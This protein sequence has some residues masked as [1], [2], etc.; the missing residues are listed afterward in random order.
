L[1]SRT[2]RALLLVVAVIMALVCAAPASAASLL[3]TRVTASKAKKRTCQARVASGSTVVKRNVTA[4]ATG[5]LRARTVGSGSGDWDLAVF[6]RRDGRLVAASAYRGPNELA[7]GIAVDREPLT[8]QACRRSGK[9]KSVRLSVD[10]IPVPAGSGDPIRLVRIQTP[11]DAS[12]RVLDSLGLDL[13]EHAREG[14]RE[15]L[16][17]S[18]ADAQK[19]RKA[20]LIFTVQVPDVAAA[21]RRAF[22]QSRSSNA[23]AGDVPSGRTEYRRLADYSADMKRLAEENPDLVKPITLPY[24]TLEGRPVEGIEITQDVKKRD[25]KPVFLQMGVHHAREWPSGEHAMEWAFEMVNGLR[26]G[27]ERVTDLL[28]RSRVIVV[29]IVNPDG[30]NLTREAGF[31]IPVGPVGLLLE[32]LGAVEEFAYKRRNCR[33]QDGAFPAAGE[34]G[35]WANRFL[36]VDPNR[37][38]GG[39][40][41]GPGASTSA[42]DDTYRGAG[43]FSE[44]ET[45]NIKALV[46]RRQV[47][48]L[49][50]NHTYSDLV[51]RPPGIKSEGDP[52]DEPVYKELGDAMAA[53]N[54][55]TSEKSWELYDTTGTTEDWSYYATGGLGFTFEIG[56]AADGPT[57]FE[58]LAGVG[59]HPPYPIGVILEYN[60]KQ[61]GGGGN[62]EAYFKALESTANTERHSVIKGEAPAGATLRL[63]KEFA[64]Y[65]SPVIQADGSITAPQSFPDVLDTTMAVDSSGKFEWHVNPSTRPFAKKSRT[66]GIP[67]DTPAVS[68][69]IAQAT[70][71]PP[72]A[73]FPIDVKADGPKGAIGAWMDGA[74]GDDWDMYLYEGS[75]TDPTKEVASSAGSS[76]DERL[77]YLSPAPG[78]YTLE[79]RYFTA[80]SGWTGGIDL[81]GEKDAVTIPAQEETWT[82]TCEQDGAVKATYQVSVERGQQVDIS[83]ACKGGGQVGAT[84]GSPGAGGEAGGGEGAGG[85]ST[86]GGSGGSGGSSTDTTA[87]A[88]RLGAAAAQ[89]ALRQHGIVA[90]VT[91]NE[92]ATAVA[93]GTIRIAGMKKALPLSRVRQSVSAGSRTRIV[94]RM[95]K[96]TA[97]ALRV[98][99]AKRKRATAQ[100]VVK[101]TDRAGNTSTAR[102]K[103]KIRR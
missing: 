68:T 35:L 22:Q 74:D 90:V 5:L 77:T 94:L 62:R 75:S 57:G 100:V 70:I 53:E 96:R 18:A 45:Q 48:T 51:L 88:V 99:L 25:G 66:L 67:A 16:L 86:G 4:A 27:D 13:T 87:P 37:N 54:G 63:H 7:E 69:P 43:P 11:T 38:Y 98:A 3:N 34:C 92:D 55:Y 36:G 41:G 32:A 83:D 59:F 29:P 28:S 79:I 76:A 56:R 95:P 20:G 47:T 58:S 78:R 101:L 33:V 19:L 12:K 93:T 82:L 72:V 2:R 40:W 52:P 39:F 49:I 50:T 31:D 6:S 91:G 65:T 24:T 89:R 85:G 21:D 9:T 71:V 26:D 23:A 80:T 61:P 97:R 42:D 103:V 102:R 15:A 8:V 64:S 44:P 17:Y 60:G 1:I 46:S 30:F 10:S 73:T 81:Y 14:F 84:G